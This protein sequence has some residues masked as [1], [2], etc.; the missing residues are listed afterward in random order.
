MFISFF[1][2]IQCPTLSSPVHGSISSSKTGPY[3][4]NDVV[5]YA[6]DDGYMLTSNGQL[7]CESGGSWSD[8]PPTC[9]G[10]L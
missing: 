4:P 7:T 1:A 9:K 5:T 2:E 10:K 3:L 8:N 6:C